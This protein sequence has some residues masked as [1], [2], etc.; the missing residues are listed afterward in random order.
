MNSISIS[1]HICRIKIF[2]PY[3]VS[4]TINNLTKERAYFTLLP[5]HNKFK[6][7]SQSKCLEADI[8]EG[9]CLL[10]YS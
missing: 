6:E 8:I 5:G 4:V 1:T 9:Y 7:E 3:S 2:Y 10:I